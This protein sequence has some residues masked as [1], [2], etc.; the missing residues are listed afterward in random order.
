MQ[1]DMAGCGLRDL[2]LQGPAA[3]AYVEQIAMLRLAIFKEYPYLY[4]GRMENELEYL[5]HYAKSDE[6]V[7]IIASSHDELAGAVTAIPLR[8]ESS[9]LISP[10]AATQYPIERIFYIGELLFYPNHRNKGLGTRLLSHIVQHVLSLDTYDYLTCA[11]VMRPD[12]HPLRPEGYVPIERFLHRNQFER[13]QGVTTQF[14]WKE[15]DGI[16]RDH[17][18]QFWIK[19]LA[20]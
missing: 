3:N 15:T 6:S 17:E 1:N 16:R 11:T 19:A 10:F 8:C 4:D 20:R 13:L 12:A 14:A 7:V 18:M 9:E 5:Q 2:F